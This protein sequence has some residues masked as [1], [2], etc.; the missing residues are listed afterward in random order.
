MSQ[1]PVGAPIFDGSATSISNNDGDLPNK[2]NTYFP[3]AANPLIVVPPGTGGECVTAGPFKNMSVNLGPGL[4]GAQ[5][6]NV[7]LN[8]QA[9]GLGYNP[10]CLRRDIS[11]YVSQ[12]ALTDADV[13]HLITARTDIA[14][15]QNDMEGL[16]NYNIS[17]LGV[18]TAG[19]FL[20]GGDPGGDFFASP[21]YAF[22]HP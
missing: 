8:P 9:D 15:F 18:H 16:F 10:R 19:H 11:K 1:D 5:Y 13:A 21:G 4:F 14:S 7:P 12:L 17:Q 3:S 6:S 22:C 2:N 20:V